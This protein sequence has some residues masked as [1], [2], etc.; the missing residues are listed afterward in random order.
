[1]GMKESENKPIACRSTHPA[2]GAPVE[3]T[4]SNYPTIGAPTRIRMPPCP[5]IQYMRPS[6]LWCKAS[7]VP[8]LSLSG[9]LGK[10]SVN[11]APKIPAEGTDRRK[12]ERGSEDD[13]VAR[14][15]MRARRS[16]NNDK[17]CGIVCKRLPEL[18]FKVKC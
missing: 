6:G 3:T 2:M 12:V 5:A 17:K 13:K 4:S 1:M 8:G 16:A 7:V 10:T 9:R 14:A 11:S 15:C 18:R